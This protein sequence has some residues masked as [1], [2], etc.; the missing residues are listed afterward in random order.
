MKIASF[1]RVPG[2]AVITLIRIYQKSRILRAPSC[3]FYPS[4]SEYMAR[5][6]EVNGLCRGAIAG[7]FR[8]LKCQ[9]FHPGGVDEIVCTPASEQKSRKSLRG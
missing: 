1:K 6:I 4:C 9:P 2:I 3:R 5:S 8:L 7:I